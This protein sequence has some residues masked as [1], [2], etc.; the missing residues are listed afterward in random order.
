MTRHRMT[1]ALTLAAC[2]GAAEAPP[3]QWVLVTAPAHRAALEPLCE[4]RKEQG[5]RV[6]IVETT[7]VL[8]KEAIRTGDA[9]KLQRHVNKLCHEFPGKSFV[10][11]VGFIGVGGDGN[12]STV[13]PPLAGSVGRMR[14][15]PTDCGYGNPVDGLP[16]VPVGRFPARTADEAAAMVRKTIDLEHDDLPGPWRRRLTVLAGVPAFNPLVDRLVETLA[17]ARLDQI[18][19]V[20][21]GR[22]IYH[23]AQSRFC[24]PDRDLHTR[25]LEY[26]CEGEALTLYLGH[27]SPEGLWAGGARFLDRSDWGQLHIRRGA[28]V[29]ATFGCYGCQLRGRGGEG[30]GIAAIR[31][32]HGPAAVLGAQG[33]CFAAMVRLASEG[34]AGS[35]LAAKPPERL[36]TAWLALLTG[37]ASG[38]MDPISYAL[39]DRVDGDPQI[40]QA[41]Q[42]REHLEMFILLGDPALRLPVLP[43]DITLTDPGPLKAGTTLAINGTLPP[44]LAG[45]RVRVTLERTA[46]SLPADLET[47]PGEAGSPHDRVMRANHERANHF[48]LTEAAAETNGVQFAA[49]L[50][51]PETFP[52]HDLILR[53]YASTERSDGQGVLRLD[54]DR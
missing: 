26:V 19:P 45:A 9:G 41:T 25:A 21:T 40:P 42:R 50:R 5:F 46:G 24:L 53:A 12:V 2:C 7:D 54:V 35:V 6:S 1:L 14:G 4:L 15:Q 32:A 30:Y 13:V 33:I 16:S 49:K 51:V 36:G 39:L 10:L 18:D 43:A 20:W 48:V 23:N 31:N 3:K 44:R 28:G 11:L 47:L 38:D 22:A 52:G 37:L 27:S 17:L 34:F 8:S 29:F